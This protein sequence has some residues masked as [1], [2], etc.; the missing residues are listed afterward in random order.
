[1]TLPSQTAP[2]LQA[3]L[4]FQGIW[5]GIKQEWLYAFKQNHVETEGIHWNGNVAI[6]MKFSLLATLNIAILT[7][8]TA[9]SEEN[10]IPVTFSI[11]V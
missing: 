9:A 4:Y 3:I 7:T 11:L 8:F 1:M 10:F 5:N 2:I 6:S